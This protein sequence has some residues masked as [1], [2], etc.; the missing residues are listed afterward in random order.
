MPSTGG[1]TDGGTGPLQLKGGGRTFALNDGDN[2]ANWQ[3]IVLGFDSGIYESLNTGK[4]AFLVNSDPKDANGI[5][6]GHP[7]NAEVL[8]VAADSGIFRRTGFEQP[9]EKLPNSPLGALDVVLSASDPNVAY[10]VSSH[11]WGTS[12]DVFVTKNGGAPSGSV[13]FDK[14]TGD[15]P[16]PLGQI[17]AIKYIPSTRG[18]RIVIAVNG[19]DFGSNTQPGAFAQ[20]G[21][22][23]MAVANPGVW[24]RLGSN[25]PNAVAHGLAYDKGTDLL[26]VATVGRGVWTMK[27]AGSVD[28]APL[29]VCK[30]AYT[31]FADAT[32]HATVAASKFDNGSVDPDGDPLTF[33]AVD[34]VTLLPIP[35][36]PY[37]LGATD[38][39]VKVA[40]NQ[41][42][43]ALCPKSTLT[44][45][46]ATPPV[47][48]V[49]A[50]KTTTSCVDSLSVSI[51]QATATDNCATSLVPTG[52]VIKKN[53]VTLPTPIP[54]ASGKVALGPGTYTVQW[55]VSDG[56][57]SV[58]ANQTVTVGAGIQVSQSFQL[59]D[60]AQLRSA[61]GGY[62]AM[63]NAGT[64]TTLVEQDCKLGGI[65]SK[66]DVTIQHRSVVNGDVVTGGKRHKD[67]DATITGTTIENATVV[68]PA[69]PTL[70]SFPTP[71]LGGFTVNAGTTVSNKGPGSY[72]SVTII[73]GGT[74]ILK[75]GDYYFQSLTINS[76]AI[77]RVTATTRIFVRDAVTFN[78][79]FL[80]SSGSAVQ[81]IYFGYAGTVDLS[82]NSVFNGTLVA[83]NGKVKFGSGSALTFTGS[84]FGRSF[85]LNPGASLV[86]SP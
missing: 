13:T 23:T 85:E 37:G 53:G 38:V 14:L 76:G 26:A 65:I 69:L 73:N 19:R 16:N 6:Y 18:D 68:L 30:S 25:L 48:T 86:C 15:L 52:Q 21:V 5:A 77:L 2:N 72:S 35:V 10:V 59:D 56:A 42:A 50:N 82:M 47:L 54:V 40:D 75:A 57:N 60:R 83:P 7:T 8:W 70:P 61:S 1:G 63:L 9:L 11:D 31:A 67:D 12:S 79:P 41:G 20:F 44:V 17:R 33:T 4:T 64:G 28:R 71:T 66:S 46:D 78:S 29:A 81:P 34:P 51:G 58:Q 45:V 3:R 36:V 62:A 27:G 49:P 43:S 39:T 32:C 80:G 55:S 22:F 74:L 84:F 24:T